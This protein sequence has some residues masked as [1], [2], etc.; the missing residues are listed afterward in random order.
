MHN[1]SDNADIETL[2]QR[3]GAS[4][5]Y[6]HFKSNKLPNTEKQGWKLLDS[7]ARYSSKADQYREQRPVGIANST[8]PTI[9][10]TSATPTRPTIPAHHH[11]LLTRTSVYEQPPVRPFNT[12]RASA[13]HLITE[14]QAEHDSVIKQEDTKNQKNFEHLFESYSPPRDETKT[15]KNTSLKNM[16]RQINLCQ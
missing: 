14:Q 5:D 4:F 11:E 9:A 16:L 12:E 3:N 13:S 2:R 10:T 15:E 8:T 7:I 1:N 6:K